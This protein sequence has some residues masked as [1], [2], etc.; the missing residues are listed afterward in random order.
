MAENRPSRPTSRF[1]RL[2]RCEDTVYLP[3]GVP[4]RLIMRFSGCADPGWPYMYH[5]HLLWHEDAGMMGQFVIVEPGQH[6]RLDGGQSGQP[7]HVHPTSAR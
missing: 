6:P 3:P 7:N 1:E 5:C 2:A 4:I